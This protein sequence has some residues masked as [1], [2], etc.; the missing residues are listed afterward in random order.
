VCKDAIL[1][2]SAGVADL[3][4]MVF[5]SNQPDITFHGGAVFSTKAQTFP[6]WFVFNTAFEIF[7]SENF[8]NS[9]FDN[10]F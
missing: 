8:L 4:V 10:T 5:M 6:L 9:P 2:Q 7:G 1:W 3:K